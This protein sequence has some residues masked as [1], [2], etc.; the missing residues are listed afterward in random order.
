M[1]PPCCV[2]G[3][4]QNVLSVVAERAATPRNLGKMDRL[5]IPVSGIH[6]AP[7][8]P[9]LPPLIEDR[10]KKADYRYGK[11]RRLREITFFEGFKGSLLH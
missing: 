7:L 3:T 1:D 6:I 9:F 8:P 5:K 11:M 10:V 2:Q 4:F